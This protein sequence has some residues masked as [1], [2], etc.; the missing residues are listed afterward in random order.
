[1]WIY[2]LCLFGCIIPKLS[3]AGDN[4]DNT[5]CVHMAM[6]GFVCIY[7]GSYVYLSVSEY[8]CEYSHHI[9][10]IHDILWCFSSYWY[11]KHIR[12]GGWGKVYSGIPAHACIKTTI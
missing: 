2:V 6:S 10:I 9:H 8:M 12:R 5:H 7:N 11:I 1:M 4:V 3:R